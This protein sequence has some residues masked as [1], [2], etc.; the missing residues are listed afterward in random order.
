[1]TWWKFATPVAAAPTL[2]RPSFVALDLASAQHRVCTRISSRGFGCFSSV[3]KAQL[4]D[5]EQALR[6][7]REH[8][9]GR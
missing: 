8:L 4:V 2:D 1:M 6:R 5:G 9:H 7:V 3:P